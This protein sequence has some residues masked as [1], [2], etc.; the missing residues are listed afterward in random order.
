MCLKK[1]VRELRG[2]IL[3]PGCSRVCST[4]VKLLD[5]NKIPT[6]ALA[7]GLWIGEIPDKL[8]NLTYAE[9]LLIAK[10]CHNRCIVKVSSGMSKMKANPISLSNPMLKIY[11]VLPPPTEE[12]DEV[13]AFIYIGP[14]KLTKADLKQTPLLVRCLK[15]SKALHW[16]KLNHVDYFYCE[17]SDRKLASYPEEGPSVV[18]DYHL[19]NPNKNPESTSVHDIE[20]EDGTTEGSCP[21]IVHGCTGEEFSTKTMKTIKAIALQHLTSEGKILSIGHAEMPGSIYGNPQLFPS[22]LPWLFSYGLGGI[23]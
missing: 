22:M 23:G 16:L 5:N 10:V 17:I 2:P 9:Q 14:C 4:S 19:L 7:N 15:V 6:L 1:L 11:N 3:A 8:K 13:L 21:F 20:E 18:V 12:M